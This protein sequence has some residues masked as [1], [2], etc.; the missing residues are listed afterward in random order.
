MLPLISDAM[1]RAFLAMLAVTAMMAGV[2]VA[3][4]ADSKPEAPLSRA[5]TAQDAKDW[6][7]ARTIVE[8]EQ[9]VVRDLVQWRYVSSSSSGATFDEISQ[10]L[11]GHA[12][13]PGRSR[14]MVCSNSGTNMPGL[15]Q[16]KS[17]PW[18]ALPSCDRRLADSAK[19][20]LPETMSWRK[21]LSCAKPLSDEERTFIFSAS[22]LGA[23]TALVG[24]FI[25]S[26]PKSSTPTRSLSPLR[27]RSRMHARALP[28]ALHVPQFHLD[29]LLARLQLVLF[30]LQTLDAGI[31][32]RRDSGGGQGGHGSTRGHGFSTVASK[33]YAKAAQL[34]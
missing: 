8:K 34:P 27:I 30:P 21:A 3:Q 9:T 24:T 25:F 28:L 12:T 11:A 22:A 1:R 14:F 2:W 13:W 10:F 29:V 18:A 16:P 33:A 17:P 19:S 20:A 5:F 6:T 32:R 15:A 23:T 4:G 7:G 31:K 26:V